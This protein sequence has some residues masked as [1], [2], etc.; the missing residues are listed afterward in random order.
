VKENLGE[1]EVA[2]V[3]PHYRSGTQG[4]QGGGSM[5][6]F[7]DTSASGNAQEEIQPQAAMTPSDILLEPL[8]GGGSSVVPLAGY[9]GSGNGAE[10]QIVLSFNT[11]VARQSE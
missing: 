5:R 11:L 7:G 6:K 2:A 10:R 8:T 9:P 3:L 1:N 4:T